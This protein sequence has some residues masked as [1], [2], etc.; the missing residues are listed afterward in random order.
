MLRSLVVAALLISPIA[1]AD[2]K[3]KLEG[4]QLVLPGPIYFET[5]SAKIKSESAPVLD[6]I[7][8]YLDDKTYI[9][10]LRIENHTDSAGSEKYNQ[11]LSGERALAV[12]KALVGKGVDCKRLVAVGFGSTKPIADNSTA[13]GRAKNRRTEAHNVALRGRLIGGMPA[14]GG[15]QDAGDVCK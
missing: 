12:A 5:G 15:G 8:A 2:S 7:K 13:E 14:D 11:K 4:N 6:H 3:F 1:L 10:T 9:T